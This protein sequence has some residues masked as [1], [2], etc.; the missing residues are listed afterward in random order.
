MHRL[1]VKSSLGDSGSELTKLR[2]GGGG[3]RGEEPPPACPKPRRLGAGLPDFLKLHKCT[4]HSQ[5]STDG[6][7][8]I[9]NMIASANKVEETVESGC[10]GCS[11]LCYVGSPPSRSDNP[12]VHD[13]EFIHQMELL[14]PFTRSKLSDRF[15]FT[16]VSPS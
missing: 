7:S 6:R 10:T 2:F 15:G 14:S 4:K 16:S 3:G 11:H 8:D 5:V 9:L 1:G 13:V 12:L